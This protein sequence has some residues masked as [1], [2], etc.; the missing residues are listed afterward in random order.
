ML[1]RID[2]KDN[3]IPYFCQCTLV[4]LGDEMR[5]TLLR[6]IRPPLLEGELES[7]FQNAL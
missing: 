5:L 2:D 4:T 6:A 1:M 7:I 3:V